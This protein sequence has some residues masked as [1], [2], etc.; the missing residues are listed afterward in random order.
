MTNN[1]IECAGLTKRFDSTTAL[2]NLNIRLPHGK[3]IGLLGPNGSGKTTL[4]KL[5]AGLLIPTSGD[6]LVEGEKIGE[7][8]KAVVSYLPD[9]SYFSNWMKVSDCLNLFATFYSDFDMQKAHDM[10]SLLG[11]SPETDYKAL[12]KGNKEKVQLIVTMARRAKLYVLDEPIAGVDPAARDYILSTILNN[13][14]EGSTILISTHLLADIEQILDEFIFLKNGSCVVY[15]S[16]ENS[17]RE[18]G[19]SLDE[20]FKEV[21]R[22]Y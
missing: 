2:N 16:V 5:I 20:F 6:I 11:I 18:T 14:A 1:L 21:F 4:I 9:K 15:N 17:R 12:S 3:I 13:Y 8:T 7:K 10:L 22:C 19:K